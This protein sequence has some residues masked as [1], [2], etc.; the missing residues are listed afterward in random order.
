V[1]NAEGWLA[2]HRDAPLT[3]LGVAQARDLAPQLAELKPERVFASDLVR[4]S[5]T[6]QLAWGDGPPPIVQD[7]AVR[8][9]HLGEWEGAALAAL[10]RSSERERLLSWARGPPGGESHQQLAMRALGFLEAH[11][12]VGDTLIF[13]H[14]GWIRTVVG[15]VDGVPFDQLGQIKV[16]NVAVLARQVPRGTWRRL[17]DLAGR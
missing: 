13:A 8:E 1:A 4:A 6:G 3:P 9:R 7:R 16:A 14:G 2:G 10:R 15:L 11:E 17:A 5:Q 12:D